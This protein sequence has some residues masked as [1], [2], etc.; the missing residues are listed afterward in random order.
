[1]GNEYEYIKR[2]LERVRE[3]I[4]KASAE[5]GFNQ[6]ITLLA[7]VKYADA[8]I[9]NYLHTELGINDIGE[10]RV[11]QLLERYDRL[12]RR[13]LNIHFI[14]SLQTNKVK[15]LI[16]KVSLIQS[17]D[18]VRL[19][20]EIDRQALKHGIVA[21]VLVE[22]NSA[23]EESKGGILPEHV[24]DFCE[25]LPDYKNIRLRGFMTM[26]S[27][28]DGRE[29]QN[30][31]FSETFKLIIDIW[32]KRLHNIDIPIISMGMSSSFV[33]AIKCGSNM[34]RLGSCLFEER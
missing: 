24:A 1:M 28:T 19:A 27:L 31:I 14:G 6:N 8:D 10:N 30:K 29:R 2:N 20:A 11:Q 5:S 4:A 13:N 15:Y 12:D 23:R 18:S 34:I 33:E 32:Q 22:I 21:D 25:M 17:L 9:V 26:G 7:A 3:K 16:D